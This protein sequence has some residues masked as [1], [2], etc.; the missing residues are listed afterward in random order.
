MDGLSNLLFDDRDEGTA[1]FCRTDNQGTVTRMKTHHG[2]RKTWS[3][4]IRN[5]RALRKAWCR[6]GACSAFLRRGW[7]GVPRHRCVI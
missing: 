5:F 1:E 6:F 2:W 3:P 4:T 7:R